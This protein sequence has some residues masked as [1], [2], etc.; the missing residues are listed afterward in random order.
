[1]KHYIIKAICWALIVVLGLG[2]ITDAL[3]G[4]GL[5]RGWQYLFNAF[6]FLLALP[7]LLYFAL[8]DKLQYE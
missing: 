6:Y 3:L 2:V 5:N 4:F 1:M 8:G 7:A